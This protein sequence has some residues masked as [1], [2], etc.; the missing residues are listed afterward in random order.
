M[1]D[2]PNVDDVSN[3]S[4]S[5]AEASVCTPEDVCNRI[6]RNLGITQNALFAQKDENKRSISGR[7]ARASNRTMTPKILAW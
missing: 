4:V 2:L 3:A 7:G 1:L 5:V 6:K